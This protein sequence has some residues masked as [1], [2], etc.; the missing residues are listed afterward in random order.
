MEIGIKTNILVFT[1]QSKSS[2]PFLWVYNIFQQNRQLCEA[3]S[4]FRI[5]R[6]G[7]DIK[8]NYLLARG[9]SNIEMYWPHQNFYWPR[10]IG[11]PLMSSPAELFR[12]FKGIPAV[13]FHT[14]SSTWSCFQS[15]SGRLNCTT[16]A[17]E[18]HFLISAIQSKLISTFVILIDGNYNCI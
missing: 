16:L 9:A 13:L 2:V 4:L 14:F 5:P 1:L 18:C 10:A 6:A 8:E 11:P 15:I 17:E 3:V 12:Y 7:L